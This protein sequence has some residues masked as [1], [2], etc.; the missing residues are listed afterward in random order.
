MSTRCLFKLLHMQQ[1]CNA[2]NRLVFLTTACSDRLV[3]CLSMTF[4]NTVITQGS[5][6]M[7]LAVVVSLNVALLIIFHGICWLT[8]LLAKHILTLL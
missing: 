5:V 1:F 2:N 8:K 7:H 6:E 3:Q 4:F